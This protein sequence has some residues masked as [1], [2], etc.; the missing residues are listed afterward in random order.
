M[1][2][3]VSRHEEQPQ[4]S[5]I[6][7]DDDILAM[8][9]RMEKLELEAEAKS[10][11]LSKQKQSEDPRLITTKIPT[12]K[13]DVIEQKRVE[14]FMGFSGDVKEH[15]VSFQTQHPKTSIEETEKPEPVIC[16][17]QTL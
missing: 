2:E 14:R 10:Q 8:L 4:G 11:E 17:W 1:E 16:S 15:D 12:R 3:S 5:E 13:Q 7:S 6:K 9:N